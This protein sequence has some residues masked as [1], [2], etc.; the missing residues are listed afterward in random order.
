VSFDSKKFFDSAPPAF[1]LV[2]KEL[3]SFGF[4]PTLIGGVVRDFYLFGLLSRDWD[5]ELAHRTLVFNRDYWKD[6]GRALAK[7]GRVTYLPFEI[8]RLE[9]R[10]FHF[11]F[12]PPRKEVF[13]PD[14]SQHG[15]KNFYAEFDY[16][17]DPELA[18]TRRDFTIN[19]IG[20]KFIDDKIEVVDP[21][22]GLKHLNEKI[23]V[24]CGEDFEKDPVRFLRAHRFA[25]KFNLKISPELQTT[26]RTMPV[27]FNSHYLWEEM[28]KSKK[29]LKMYQSLLD[30]RLDLPLPIQ[31]IPGELAH[32]L[33][34][35]EKHESW[36]LALAWCGLDATKWVTYFNVGSE[37]LKRLIRWSEASQVFKKILPEKFQ[38]E[39]EVVLKDPEFDLLFNW[40]FTTNQI[41]G[42]DLSLP[43]LK[44]IEEFLPAWIHL[45]RFE[46]V[47]DVRHIDPPLRARYQVWNLCQ[48]L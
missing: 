43:L 16:R 38:A 41:L 37:S 35:P 42:K 22:S 36:V 11:E 46:P 45:Y 34:S 3:H 25:L 44:I 24:A 28:M 47:K 32:L 5:I 8:I 1:S 19:A 21:L 2:L 29:P 33:T 14:W 12:S 17:L 10:D 27:N 30:S 31:N 15:H 4:I 6:L 48:R 7:I 9:V 20:L 40:Y 13:S 39:F 23:L 18:A 26:L